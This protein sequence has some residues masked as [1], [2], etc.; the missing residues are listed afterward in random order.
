MTELLYKISAAGPDIV[1][2]I[3][4]YQYFHLDVSEVR[5][6]ME[7]MAENNK[8]DFITITQRTQLGDCY[9]IMDKDKFIMMKD[10][11]PIEVILEE[12]FYISTEIDW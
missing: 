10:E 4:P 7:W 8:T 2:G 3:V 5:K 9:Y 12:A 6:M 11:A 1:R